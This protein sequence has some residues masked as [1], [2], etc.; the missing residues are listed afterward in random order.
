MLGSLAPRRS[1]SRSGGMSWPDYLRLWEQFGFNGVQYV[2]PGG[3]IGE[4]TAMQAQ[5]NP[6]VWACISVRI[7]VFSEIRLAYQQWQAGKP[8]AFS[9]NAN[10]SLLESPWPQATTG[11]LLARM[12]VDVSMYG[13]SY[14]VKSGKQLVRLDPTRMV[15]ATTDALDQTTGNA[16]GKML[17]GYMLNDERG[18]VAAIFTPDEVCHYRPIPDPAHEFRGASW[19][20]ALLPDVIADLDLTDYKHSFLQNAATPNLAVT[21]KEGVSQEAFNNFRD[22][23]ESAHTGPQSGFK[24]LYLGAGADVKTVGSNFADL[25]MGVVQS[26]GET[27]IAAAA[28]VPAGIV[29]LAESMKGSTLNSGNYQAIRRRFSDGTIRPLWRS[30]CGALSTLVTPPPN[31]RLWY[32][33]GDVAF[34]QDDATD[35]AA[36]LGTNATTMATLF[37]AGFD[38]DSI[39]DAV[40]TGDFT[41]LVHTGVSSVQLQGGGPKP[42]ALPAPTSDPSDENYDDPNA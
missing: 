26:Q 19:L 28:G 30:A 35:S 33:A 5:R 11:D 39:I 34:L 1:E 14:W 37:Q 20:N 9:G 32:D 3:N 21:F 2:I 22:K 23:M 25:A 7:L 27:R 6:I 8:G 18:K 12:E 40:T 41:K 29:G 13:N 15:I 38:P 10:L 4:L 36:V 42:P 17:V 24:T 16:F 31:T